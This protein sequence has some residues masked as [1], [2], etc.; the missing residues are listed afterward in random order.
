MGYNNN[1]DIMNVMNNNNVDRITDVDMWIG[2]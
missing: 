2:I 1:V